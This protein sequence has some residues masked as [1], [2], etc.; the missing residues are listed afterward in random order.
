M[1]Y[2]TSAT[3]RGCY[4][5]DKTK[6][7]TFLSNFRHQKTRKQTN[8]FTGTA[9]LCALGKTIKLQ[10]WKSNYSPTARYFVFF[11]QLFPDRLRISRLIHVP[12]FPAATAT[13][14]VSGRAYCAG[15]SPGSSCTKTR[16]CS[17]RCCTRTW[18]CTMATAG[19]ASPPFC[20]GH[21]QWLSNPAMACR[22]RCVTRWPVGV[23]R[24][25]GATGPDADEPQTAGTTACCAGTTGHPVT[26][27]N[28]SALRTHTRTHTLSC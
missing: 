13:V 4:F 20:G 26:T 3:T 1:T 5:L 2:G 12:G 11:P 14:A 27:S 23:T 6:F 24:D 18:S 21:R 25:T 17:L 28:L 10:T 15:A 22:G 7:P 16:G 19:S 8:F 9:S